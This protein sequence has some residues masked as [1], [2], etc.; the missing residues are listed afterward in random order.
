MRGLR[1]TAG[2]RSEPRMLEIGLNP[3]GLTYILGLQGSGTPR[4]NP[5]GAGL[6]GL[7]RP[8]PASSAPRRSRSASHGLRR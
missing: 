3:Y 1:M 8:S 6:E 4:A 5:N 7:H 2:V